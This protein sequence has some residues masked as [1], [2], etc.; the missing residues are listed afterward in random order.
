VLVCVCRIGVRSPQHL[1][2]GGVVG[3]RVVNP[4]TRPCCLFGIGSRLSRYFVPR[5]RL[6]PYIGTTTR[7]R[8]T[9]FCVPPRHQTALS[10]YRNVDLF[11]IG[12]AFR[13]HLRD[14]LT[15]S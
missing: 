3:S 14:R 1:R 7:R 4:L 5:K 8:I 12:Y 2:R 11:P 9:R 10:W 15:L 6:P 13:P